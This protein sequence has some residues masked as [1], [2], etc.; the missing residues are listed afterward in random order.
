MLLFAIYT[1]LHGRTQKKKE[2]KN[3]DCYFC[4][5]QVKAIEF[6]EFELNEN[7]Q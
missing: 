6:N 1:I 7:E 4:M 2:K 5:D 3:S